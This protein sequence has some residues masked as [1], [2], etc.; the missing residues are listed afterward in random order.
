MCAGIVGVGG[1]LWGGMHTGDVCWRCSATVCKDV[2]ISSRCSFVWIS[3]SWWGVVLIVFEVVW[4]LLS[5]I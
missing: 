4:L 3:V 5:G 2:S 1:V